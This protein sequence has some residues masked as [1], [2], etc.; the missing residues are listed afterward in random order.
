MF[1]TLR[2]D[3]ERTK[4]DIASRMPGR[5]PVGTLRVLLTVTT[6]PVIW[7]RFGN[8]AVKRKYKISRSLGILLLFLTKPLMQIF[9]RVLI[10]HRAQIGPGFVIR[11]SYGLLI[12]PHTNIGRNFTVEA[13]CVI[14]GVYGDNV[15]FAPGAKTLAQP[16][17]GNNVVVTANSLVL[18]DV[19][20]NATVYG[21]PARA[22][23]ADGISRVE[24]RPTPVNGGSPNFGRVEDTSPRTN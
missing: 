5:R 16:R 7:L 10:S 15:Y 24:P 19:R 12:G 2:A 6:W 4:A 8:W 18:A 14:S 3:I 1:E 21:I 17:I 20:D 11:S 22:R 9:A 13:G 23:A